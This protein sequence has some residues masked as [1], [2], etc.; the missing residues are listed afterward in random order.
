MISKKNIDKIFLIFLV[1][2]LIVWTLIPALTNT[3]LPLDTIEA[4][5]WSSKLEWGYYKH[6]PFS[7]LVVGVVYFIFGSY[8]WIYYLLSQILVT[9]AFIYVWKLSLEF[10][11]DK[12][13]YS[14]QKFFAPFFDMTEKLNFFKKSKKMTHGKKRG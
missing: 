4:L 11:D 7:A 10:F 13:F 5:A 1:S 12:V 3:N 9:I 2:H 14:P 8:D 6:P